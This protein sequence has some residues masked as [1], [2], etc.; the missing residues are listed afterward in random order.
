M[1]LSE[2]LFVADGCELASRGWR[3]GFCGREEEATLL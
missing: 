1:Q 2:D 3:F